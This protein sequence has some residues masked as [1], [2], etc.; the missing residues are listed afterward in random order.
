M[1]IRVRFLCAVRRFVARK[2]MKR[3]KEE[4]GEP[5]FRELEPP[6]RLAPPAAGAPPRRMKARGDWNDIPSADGV[7]GWSLAGVAGQ[8]SLRSRGVPGRV[9]GPEQRQLA[10][11]CG[12]AHVL[13]RASTGGSRL[14]GAGLPV[15]GL[16]V[17]RT[18]A[19]RRPRVPRSFLPRQ[20][21]AVVHQLE[22]TLG[23]RIPDQ[24]ENRAPPH[25]DPFDE[26]P[27]LPHSRQNH[28]GFRGSV[29]QEVFIVGE[30]QHVPVEQPLPDVLVG[31]AA[32]AK[33]DDVLDVL[34]IRLEAAVQ[35]EGKVL[36][37]ED[38]QDA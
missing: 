1:L 12:L 11:A 25:L 28:D 22:P 14:A 33:R 26:P 30:E 24:I 9:R 19:L 15:P 32:Q 36:V 5:N 2:W 34:A 23:P 7:G 37:E 8:G 29:E 18:R 3:L 4:A 6:P 21:G 27:R 13:G 20:Q 38:L 35:R 17:L 10:P 31:R 16:A